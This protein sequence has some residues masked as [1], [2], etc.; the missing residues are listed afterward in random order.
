MAVIKKDGNIMALPL[1]ISRGYPIALDA[2]QVWYEKAQMEAYAKTDPTAYPGQYLTFVD[3]TNSTVEAYV[4]ANTVGTL[5]KLASTT[6]SGDVSADIVAL[7]GRCSALETRMDTVEKALEGVSGFE[8]EVVEA[9]PAAGEKGKIYLLAHSHGEKDIYDEYIWTGET[10]EKIGNTDVDLTN[11]YTKSEID[12]KITDALTPINTALDGK[13][14]LA[15]N[16]TAISALTGGGLVRR[17]EDNT[18]ELDSAAYIT[19]TAL[20]PYVT[21][22]TLGTVQTVIEA[23]EA[24]INAINNETTGILAQAKVYTDEKAYDDSALQQS[25]AD[26][27]SSIEAL[28]TEVD[29]VKTSISEVK[30]TA[31]ANKTAITAIN[32]AETGILA[33][34]QSYADN[35]AAAN[36]TLIDSLTDRVSTAE[37]SLAEKASQSALEAEINRAK[38][39]EKK[40]EDAINLILDN[41]DSETIDSIKELTEYVEKDG[42]TTASLVNR[43][44]GI[45]GENEPA[46]VMAAIEAASVKI[47]TDDT[48]GGLRTSAKFTLAEN[49]AVSAI[50][51][52]LLIQGTDEF[53]LNGGSAN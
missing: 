2:T 24:A 38:A 45:G 42:A 13:Q 32:N 51:T 26:N 34:A 47:A 11:Y 23:N 40:N 14:P 31:D 7:Q 41:P 18:F 19:A 43:L 1:S 15:A 53:V 30:A 16:L 22:E 12:S 50:S 4:I 52:D 46:T 20:E 49:G 35:K 25:V 33:Q 21:T 17:K 36:K 28:D 3:E 10:Y 48:I 44:A 9:L 27:T 39:A 8:F 5:V 6:A 37:T 29:T